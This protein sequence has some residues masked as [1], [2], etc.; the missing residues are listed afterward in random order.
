MAQQR[1]L[2]I[3]LAVSCLG[4]GL[5]CARQQN[6]PPDAPGAA[7]TAV[8]PIVTD[9]GMVFSGGDTVV[10]TPNYP[11]LN[12]LIQSRPINDPSDFKLNVD[13]KELIS[14]RFGGRVVMAFK[15]SG[16]THYGLWETKAGTVPRQQSWDNKYEGQA[17]AQYNLWFTGANGKS[18][19]RGFY[20]DTKR[21]IVFVIDDG[22]NQ[23][24]GGALTNLSG[25]VYFKTF[26]QA[27]TSPSQTTV[28]CWYQG[29]V[30][31][32][33]CATF[34]NSGGYISNGLVP[35]DGYQLMGEFMGLNR[36]K[37]FNQ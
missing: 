13:L 8:T 6:N 5:G 3:L 14:G 20:Q 9:D 16:F 4:L 2:T 17:F 7:A 26:K 37:A 24:D 32:F 15:D 34:L 1:I 33:F 21:A 11:I 27:M 18:V 30:S 35:S 10:F 19:F 23:G 29:P 36:S 31:P 22:F 25:K 28:P 12:D